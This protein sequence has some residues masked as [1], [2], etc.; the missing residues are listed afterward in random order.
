MDAR[1]DTDHAAPSTAVLVVEDDAFLRSSIASF[2]EQRGFVVS[3]AGCASDAIRIL[4]TGTPVDVIFTDARMPGVLNG[5]DLARWVR[6]ERPG[7]TVI[8]TSADLGASEPAARTLGARSVIQ[9]PYDPETV[10][11]HIRED[12]M[13]S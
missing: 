10:E 4:M 5:L 2:L 1:P 12:S 6:D 7:I 8:V 13:H 3:A 9:K 11:S